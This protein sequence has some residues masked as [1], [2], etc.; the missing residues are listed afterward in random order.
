MDD[1]ELLNMHGLF[2]YMHGLFS[3]KKEHDQTRGAALCLAPWLA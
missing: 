1:E 2:S 3:L